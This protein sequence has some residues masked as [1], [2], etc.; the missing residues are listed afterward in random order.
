MGIG[1][2]ALQIAP[3]DQLPREID[4]I[5]PPVGEDLP[6]LPQ[7]L[8]ALLRR[9][10]GEPEIAADAALGVLQKAQAVA[11]QIQNIPP[12]LL[13]QGRE[14]RVL[15]LVVRRR[16][17]V[18]DQAPGG[19]AGDARVVGPAG[20]TVG[21][22]GEG[23]AQGGKRQQA[24]RRHGQR[25]RGKPPKAGQASGLPALPPEFLRQQ[26]DHQHR[27]HHVHRRGA[28]D[29]GKAQI[30]GEVDAQPVD[31]ARQ[32]QE[33]KE[34]SLPPAEQEGEEAQDAQREDEVVLSP[35]HEQIGQGIE[36]GQGCRQKEIQ[37]AAPGAAPVQQ[38]RRRQGETPQQ[39]GAEVGI[40]VGEG[41][42]KV[43]Q[44]GD[45][46]RQLIG[47]LRQQQG[48]QP[49]QQAQAAVQGDAQEEQRREDPAARRKEQPGP[50]GKDPA[51]AFGSF[52]RGKDK[53]REDLISL[54][55]L[56]KYFDITNP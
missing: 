49:R 11:G 34:P 50:A 43:P 51:P 10:E 4:L 9:D 20:E 24:D 28:V 41:P 55:V 33:G 18:R 36:Q 31:Q 2:E 3:V 17:R 13:P 23:K 54:L 46:P 14:G 56:I 7:L 42:I 48:D 32:I 5:R 29:A 26:A 47:V 39:H 27:R 21:V 38:Q 52:Q 35:V 16:L 22:R 40:A 25:R 15:R 30:G 44:P 19:P 45:E 37:P 1:G 6:V 12:G 53:H 8:K